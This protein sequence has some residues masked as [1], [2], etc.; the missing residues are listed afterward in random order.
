MMLTRFEVRDRVILKGHPE[1]PDG[2]LGTI[3]WP[4]RFLISHAKP[5]EWEGHRR[6]IQGRTRLIVFYYVEFDQPTDDGSG[7]GPYRGAEID[8]E[9]LVKHDP[10]DCRKG[11]F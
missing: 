1:F 5:G 9:Y 4:M 3:A 7:D 10:T 6:T 2:T 8:E 11:E